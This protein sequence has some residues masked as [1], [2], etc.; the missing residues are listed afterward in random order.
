MRL[1]PP[2]LPGPDPARLRRR[3]SPLDAG[4]T[5]SDEGAARDRPDAP[6]MDDEEAA[7]EVET[8][9]AAVAPAPDPLHSTA[10]L[11]LI[12]RAERAADL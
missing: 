9:A 7:P 5:L 8:P 12:T 1:A 4:A 6:E 11:S 2:A 3:V 10:Y